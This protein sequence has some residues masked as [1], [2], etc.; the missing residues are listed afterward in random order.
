[1]SYRIIGN[2]PGHL[3]RRDRGDEESICK[4]NRS[5]ILTCNH[6]RDV[7]FGCHMGLI[8]RMVGG[9]F[10]KSNGNISSALKT[11]PSLLFNAT[12]NSH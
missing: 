9:L 5:R 10:G 6:R 2:T 7:L 8:N 4:R 11:P 12:R 3:F 1:M